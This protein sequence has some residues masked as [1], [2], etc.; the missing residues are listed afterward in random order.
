[1]LSIIKAGLR[2]ESI[3]FLLRFAALLVT[4]LLLVDCV[5]ERPLGWWLSALLM[6]LLILIIGAINEVLHSPA[7]VELL[8][9]E[10]Q[11]RFGSIYHQPNET[12]HAI[13]VFLP[14]IVGFTF[15]PKIR[16]VIHSLLMVTAVFMGLILVLSESRGGLISAT[17]GLIILTLYTRK[18]SLFLMVILL[19]ISLAYSP[20][21]IEKL[22]TI[23]QRSAI[24]RVELIEYGFKSIIEHP[25][26]GIGVRKF[27]ELGEYTFMPL[28]IMGRAPHNLYLRLA[29]ETG[30]LGLVAFLAFPSYIWRKISKFKEQKRK[31]NRL[32]K[33]IAL[34]SFVS[35]FCSY[36]FTGGI[37]FFPKWISLAIAIGL[38]EQF[39]SFDLKNQKVSV[40]K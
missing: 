20:G 23:R 37:L 2:I 31:S 34:S 13:A 11:V 27:R 38:T 7:K 4:F 36:F 39:F 17:A 1:V 40:Q 29:V 12:A 26:L 19:G 14:M 5:R 15:F 24:S 18:F 32:I 9:I 8:S 6:S 21:W 3:Y 16:R 33:G 25:F 22:A 10:G 30:I 35:V 28:E